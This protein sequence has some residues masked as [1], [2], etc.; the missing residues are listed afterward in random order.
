MSLV[1]VDKKQIQQSKNST[2]GTSTKDN[3]SHII[4]CDFKLVSHCLYIM[5]DISP[6]VSCLLFY[7]RSILRKKL[8]SMRSTE[9]IQNSP[10]NCT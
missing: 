3:Q 2:R 1:S 9:A 6:F 7:G 5:Y 10:T 8:K 4:P